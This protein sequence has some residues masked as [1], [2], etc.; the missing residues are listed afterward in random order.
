[1]N[2]TDTLG[3]S[4]LNNYAKGQWYISLIDLPEHIRDLDIVDD[5]I[6]YCATE[7]ALTK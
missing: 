1:M 3:D 4:S 6:L 7:I 5:D 2:E